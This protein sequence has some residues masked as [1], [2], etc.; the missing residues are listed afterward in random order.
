MIGILGSSHPGHELAPRLPQIVF[1]QK[2]SMF[3]LEVCFLDDATVVQL[4]RL[5]RTVLSTKTHF[6]Q[7]NH[8]RSPKNVKPIFRD[9]WSGRL[10]VLSESTA[11]YSLF[12]LNHWSCG[13]VEPVRC[14][15]SLARA[16]V[17]RRDPALHRSGKWPA[18]VPP[19]AAESRRQQGA[20]AGARLQSF[21]KQRR[22]EMK[23]SRF[24][25]GAPKSLTRGPNGR[26]L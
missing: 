24:H 25:A 21:A 23:K 18:G 5:R 16:F 7:S 4:S 6:V 1:V 17:P 8:L 13:T 3:A 26:K 12:A 11:C 9:L 22:H 14:E 19:G 10:F 20:W 2:H 15:A